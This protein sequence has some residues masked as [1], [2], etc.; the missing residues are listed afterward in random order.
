M[1]KL[2]AVL[3]PAAAITIGLSSPAAAQ[4]YPGYGYDTGYGY[5][6]PYG[7]GYPPPGYGAPAP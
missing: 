1:N 7:Y 4:S 5:Q 6:Q 2:I 3:L